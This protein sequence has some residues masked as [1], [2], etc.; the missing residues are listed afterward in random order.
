M[1]KTASHRRFTSSLLVAGLLLCSG[2]LALAAEVSPALESLQ[3]ERT[4]QL[5]SARVL[6]TLLAGTRT[7]DE[8]KP[9]FAAPQVRLPGFA[10]TG[11]KLTPA[12]PPLARPLL[13]PRGL[14]EAA[15]L[16]TDV[17]T[18]KLVLVR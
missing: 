13:P 12:C 17:V 4:A 11:P 8:V 14:G 10:S 3:A 18:T 2:R 1:T 16:D 5:R 9:S 15:A 7:R 6:S